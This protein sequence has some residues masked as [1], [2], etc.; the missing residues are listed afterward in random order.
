MTF[1]EILE[2]TGRKTIACLVIPIIGGVGIKA[3]EKFGPRD[4]K[5]VDEFSYCGKNV[6]VF[7]DKPVIG[8]CTYYGLTEKG[9]KIR[10][11]F[12]SDDGKT[13]IINKYGYEIK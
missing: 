2:F 10:G 4:I 13:I 1:R 12:V 11:T 3:M 8:G 5:Q 9:G 6:Q 7:W